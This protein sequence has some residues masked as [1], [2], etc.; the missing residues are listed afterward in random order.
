MPE[1][2]TMVPFP[3]KALKILIHELRSGGEPSGIKSSDLVD[4]K[5]EDGVRHLAST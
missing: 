3:V 5:S 2:W 4:S 1:E